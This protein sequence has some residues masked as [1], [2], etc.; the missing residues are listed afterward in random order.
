VIC[1]QDR[2]FENIAPRLIFRAFLA[3]LS[4]GGSENTWDRTKR[5]KSLVE[6]GMKIR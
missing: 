3:G 1:L 6:F 5:V 2:C 4:P